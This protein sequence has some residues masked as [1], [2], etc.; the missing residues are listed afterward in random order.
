VAA[1]EADSGAAQALGLEVDAGP[2]GEALLRRLVAPLSGLGA[3]RVTA[4]DGGADLSPLR[5]AMVPVLELRQDGT[6]YFDWHHSAA[7]TLDKV[8]PRE[9]NQAA[10]ALA[11]TAWILAEA[12]EALPRPTS[13]A[14]R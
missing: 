4:G 7:D 5:R 3:G 10:A 14:A 11:V 13:P 2:G 9:L 8:E 12:G 6:H 1:I